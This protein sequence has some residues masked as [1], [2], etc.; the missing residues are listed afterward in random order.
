MA[1][2]NANKSPDPTPANSSAPSSK[3]PAVSNLFSHLSNSAI[4]LVSL[5][6]FYRKELAEILDYNPLTRTADAASNVHKKALVIDK[7]I[8]GSLGLVAEV[9]LL[10][11]HG[12]EEIFYLFPGELTA[13]KQH[14]LYLIRP[15][16]QSIR[17]VAS[18]ILAHHSAGKKHIYS[19]VFVPRRTMLCERELEQ[20]GVAGDVAHIA[21]FHFDLIPFDSD[22]L[23]LELSPA[24]RELYI[25]GEISSLHSI[26]KSI[27][28]LQTVAGLIP[29]VKGKGNNALRVFNLMQRMRREY[30]ISSGSSASASA[31]S[32]SDISEIILLDRTV[33][34]VSPLLTQCTYEG[35]ID[36]IYGIRNGYI[37]VDAEIIGAKTEGSK[38]LP[39]SSNDNLYKE[40]RD[41]PFRILGPL[42]HKK[43][44][45]IKET[46][47]ERHSAVTV[48]E[49]HNF[50]QKFKSAHAEHSLL[51]THINL[52]EKIAI[53]T[54]SKLFDRRL[55]IE[56][57]I[58]DALDTE[59]VEEYIDNSIAKQANIWI[60]LRLICL[61]VIT[62][63][64]GI[65]PKK[66]EFWKAGIVQT[67]GFEWLF[68][69]QNLEKLGLFL[70][71]SKRPFQQIK[72]QLKLAEQQSQSFSPGNGD[73]S[74]I[75][76]G[77]S[78]LSVRLVELAARG[79]WRRIEEI[80]NLL[81][82]K[83]FEYVQEP[84]EKFNSS[85][86]APVNLLELK[87]GEKGE[88]NNLNAALNASS[89][90]SA[91]STENLS[92]KPLILVYFIGGVT[93]SEISALRCLSESP[94]HP[95]EYI[96]C[97]TKLVNGTTLLESVQEIVQNRLNKASV[98][99]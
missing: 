10:R 21:Q 71:N 48:N 39:L 5:R 73:I 91:N 6:E 92:K 96:V 99:K 86:A 17:V 88:K 29:V 27:I 76:N 13:T 85:S 52:A 2:V 14:I 7:S 58:L 83:A 12:V 43:A 97:T 64:K 41:L 3:A 80:L 45:Y 72:K 63:S 50:M 82:G 40:T 87:T 62:S 34:L 61:H 25:D 4:N 65:S 9:D 49:M 56:K 35:L 79:G 46:Y 74:Y 28:K 20:L 60:V 98:L 55:D 31:S 37:E 70:P 16:L 78:P 15:N 47:S 94:N 89:P 38:K 77:Y 30:M 59:N 18:H 53:I 26:A 51:Q 19:I 69:L 57:A 22:I 24:F 32:S 93:F 84:A 68:T 81:P 23:S 90:R 1:A 44:E 95:Y 36:E 67:Y 75:Y 66:F 33:D 54:K 8:S 42:L 11:S